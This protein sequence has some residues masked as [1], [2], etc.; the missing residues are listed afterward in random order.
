[1][2]YN[3]SECL[4]RMFF[5]R[6]NLKIIYCNLHKISIKHRWILIISVWVYFISLIWRSPL[7]AAERSK[8]YREK[9]K[10][11]LLER[12]ALKRRLKRVEIKIT[13]PKKNKARLLKKRL[14]KR[15]YR[16]RIKRNNQNQLVPSVSESIE[17]GFS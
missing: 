8:R 4:Y 14:Y 5:R 3:L 15:D 10:V 13:N 12:D 9:N 16:K 7:T 2:Q 11:K 1:M 6:S 17:G